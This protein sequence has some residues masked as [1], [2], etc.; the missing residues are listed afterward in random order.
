MRRALSHQDAPDPGCTSAFRWHR[1]RSCRLLRLLHS[2]CMPCC[3]GPPTP[4]GGGDQLP[5]GPQALVGGLHQPEGQGEPLQVGGCPS[6]PCLFRARLPDR[7]VLSPPLPRRVLVFEKAN[8]Y[9]SLLSELGRPLTLT[10]PVPPAR[11]PPAPS[12]PP[13]TPPQPTLA[14]APL[15]GWPLAPARWPAAAAPSMRCPVCM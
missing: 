15:T 7:W 9:G 12:R 8:D 13:P 4:A 14:A 6:Q 1:T 10:A 2:K 3:S 11:T 5:Q